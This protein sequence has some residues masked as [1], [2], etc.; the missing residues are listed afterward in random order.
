MHLFVRILEQ[1]IRIMSTKLTLSVEKQV[2]QKAK[3]Y[4]RE[5]GRSL[6]G[7]IQKYLENLTREETSTKISPKFKR[8]GRCCENSRGF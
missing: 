2:V 1:I 4:S 7:I 3:N 5:T 8:F 6:S